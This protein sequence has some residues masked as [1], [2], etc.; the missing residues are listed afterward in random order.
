MNLN[1]NPVHDTELEKDKHVSSV[2]ILP[3]PNPTAQS[4]PTPSNWKNDNSAPLPADISDRTHQSSSQSTAN[5]EQQE[6]TTSTASIT[7]CTIPEPWAP[8]V[9]GTHIWQVYSPLQPDVFSWSYHKTEDSEE[10][11]ILKASTDTGHCFIVQELS[12]GKRFEIDLLK[13][14]LVKL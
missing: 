8:P 11:K 7:T 10:Y 2:T 4:T 14:D 3:F 12:S 13:E 5:N 9:P 6:P 1:Y